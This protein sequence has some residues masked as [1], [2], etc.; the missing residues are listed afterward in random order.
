MYCS[1]LTTIDIPNSVTSIEVNLF[2]QCSSLTSIT[3]PKSLTYIEPGAFSGC[4]ALTS[5]EVENDN[6]KYDSRNNCNAIIETSSNTLIVGC[7]NT[8]FPS[9]VTSIGVCAFSG[10]AEITTISIPD[11]VTSIGL[12]AFSGC[13]GLTSIDIPNSVT[14]IGGSAFSDCCSLSSVIIPNSVTSIDGSAFG[15]CWA[16]SDFYCWAN[17]VPS[18][19]IHAF[20]MTP[21]NKATLHV[22]VGSVDTY[23]NTSPWSLFGTIVAL[24]DDDPKPT[25]VYSLK[26]DNNISPEAT[27][28]LD[29][30]RLS[31]P[32]RGLNI[33]RMSD[34]STKKVMIK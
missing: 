34:G 29:G 1:G 20:E 25:G 16:L 19:S 28:S 32:Q 8:T 13:S 12:Y 21:C 23:K 11:N 9:S 27:F 2:F 17:N 10:H 30:R 31:N 5:I 6:P 33:I 22:P 24:T 18:T 7:K 14:F 15:N 4:C 26:V 3:I